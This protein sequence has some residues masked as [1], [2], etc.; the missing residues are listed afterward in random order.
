MTQ[1]DI[2]L[3][4]RKCDECNKVFN[5]GFCVGGGTEYYCSDECLHKN[6][7]KEEWLDIYK[8]GDNESFWT[9]WEPCDADFWADGEE[10]E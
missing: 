3:Y 8:D 10:V 4:A 7:T 6:Y 1:S 2:W 9:E 5:E